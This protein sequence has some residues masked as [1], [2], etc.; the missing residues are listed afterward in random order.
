MR[1]T[2]ENSMKKIESSL[3]TT[4]TPPVPPLGLRRRR[5]QRNWDSFRFAGF[6]AMLLLLS[7]DIDFNY[8]HKFP[9]V[10][11]VEAFVSRKYSNIR[12]TNTPPTRKETPC[13][14]HQSTTSLQLGLVIEPL[15][16]IVSVAKALTGGYSTSLVQ[17]PLPT[18]S[19]TAGLLCGVSDV[20]AQKRAAAS[21]EISNPSFELDPKR[22]LRF[23]SKGCL[24]GILW[25]YWYDWIDGFLTYTS[26][27]DETESTA[28]DASRVS[29]Y[30]LLGSVATPESHILQVCREHSGAVK[31]AVSMLMEQLVWC[32][33]VYG[34]FE[35]PVSTLLNG[36]RPQTIPSEV[37]SKLNG[38]L[39]SNFQV[40]TP[41]NLVI[42]NAPLEWRLFLGNVIDVFWQ[43]IVSDV[44]ADCG[45]EQE[46]CI[47]PNDNSVED[48]AEEVEREMTAVAAKI[49][50]ERLY[51][52]ARSGLD[53]RNTAVSEL[54]DNESR[55]R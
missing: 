23:A 51:G 14:I 43:S 35:I 53:S 15:E 54:Y 2:I 31:T 48:F 41:A 19:L 49:E 46:E 22:T 52:N 32:P 29:F 10:N 21:D 27:A 30:A 9:P 24:G 42:Y 4:N 18:K 3:P 47:V 25:M 45:G 11:A 6:Y 16:P 26:F 7:K 38:L 1:I 5:R 34:T 33:L 20:I 8:C 37:R 50:K 44:A 55:I 40:W 28:V 39:V 13:G 17:N 36:A 12:T